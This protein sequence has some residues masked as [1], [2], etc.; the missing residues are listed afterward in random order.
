MLATRWARPL[1]PGILFI[2]VYVPLHSGVTPTDLDQFRDMIES[3][4]NSFQGD[5][6]VLG[7]DFNFD[8]WRFEER[9][10]S[11]Q[12]QT[13]LVRHL[14]A[15]VQTTTYNLLRFPADRVPTFTENLVSSTI[16][17]WFTS[18]S[19][20]VR[21]CDTIRDILRQHIPLRLHAQVELQAP[22]GLVP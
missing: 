11:R 19:V 6:L 2:N 21:S 3:L 20:R 10:A 7:G 17:H 15:L 8:P 22:S 1:A 13:P 9:R 5:S 18:S 4:R 16:D 14:V 12:Q